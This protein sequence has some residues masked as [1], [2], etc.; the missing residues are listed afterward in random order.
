MTAVIQ[1]GQF[2]DAPELIDPRAGYSYIDSSDES[3]DLP[4]D[5]LFDVDEVIDETYEDDRVEDE[6]W[7][8]AE[9][10]FTK[11]YNRL[12]QHVAVRSGN[13]Q[14]MSSALNQSTSVAAL[15]AINHPRSGTTITST[16]RPAAKDKTTDQL[17]VLSKYNSRLS[18]IDVPYVLGVGIN[19]KGPSASANLKDK[20]DRATNEQ[21]LDPRTRLILFKMI[22]RE[23]IHEVNGCVSTGKEANV[24]HALTPD[25]THL[26]LKIYKTSILVFKDRDKYVTGEYRF[27][28]GYSRKNPRKMVRLWAEKEMRN[29]KRLVS[30]GIRCPDPV[31]VRENILV[32]TFLGDKEGWASPRLKYAQLSVAES[33]DLYMELILAIRKM[34]HQCKLVHADLSEYNILFHEGHLW[35]IDVSQSVEHDH[36]SAFDFLRKDISNVEDFFSRLGVKC[37][38]LRRVFEFV[39]KEILSLSSEASSDEDILRKWIENASTEENAASEHLESLIAHEDSVFKE[40]YIPRTLNELYDPERDVAAIKRGEGAK[41]IYA[42][43]IDLVDPSSK[44][45]KGERQGKS[46][47]STLTSRSPTTVRFD[48]DPA[49]GAV[50]VSETPENSSGSGS[51]L[52]SDEEADGGDNDAGSAGVCSERKPRGHRHEDREAKK[53][54]KKAVKAEAKEKRQN[55][56]PKSEKKRMMKKSARGG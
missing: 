53:E 30:A 2:D 24:Y 31:E 33:N 40:S 56:M 50:R 7:E 41:L 22:G 8:M 43:T 55:K 10:D 44:T 38:G 45:D 46:H 11:Q 14:G 18:K 34:F 49:G 19:R 42:D 51:D 25:S 23:L 47:V 36:P 3:D 6:D 37:L 20:S 9:R 26:A 16:S 1:D 13:A 29:L 17:A 21:V 32:M 35:I 28:R 4:E 54:R 5:Q 52:D 27:R 15:P 48:V 39:I 12:R